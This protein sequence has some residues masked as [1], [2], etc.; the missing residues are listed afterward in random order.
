MTPLLASLASS[1][2]QTIGFSDLPSGTLR[3]IYVNVVKPMT[4][5]LKQI[6]IEQRH[7]NEA[8]LFCT[9]NEFR[10]DGKTVTKLIGD[11]VKSNDD[12]KL[13]L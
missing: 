9:E 4:K 11:N 13:Q 10:T 7:I 8:E 5:D 12:A 6:M 2:T 1:S 3:A